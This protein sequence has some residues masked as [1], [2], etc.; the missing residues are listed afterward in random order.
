MSFENTP[1]KTMKYNFAIK[2][3]NIVLKKDKSPLLFE[4]LKKL[5]VLRFLFRNNF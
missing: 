2:A 4:D 5:S 1:N 3:K